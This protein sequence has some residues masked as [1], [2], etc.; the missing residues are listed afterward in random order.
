MTAP[1]RPKTEAQARRWLKEAQHREEAAK[2]RKARNAWRRVRQRRAHILRAIERRDNLAKHPHIVHHKH[3]V[4]PGFEYVVRGGT[5][6]ER[7]IFAWRYAHH[8]ARLHYSEPGL[9]LP[10]Y[11]LHNVPSDDDRSDCSW[12]FLECR[13]VCGLPDFVHGDTVRYTESIRELGREVDQHFAERH[14]GVAVLFG[15]PTFHVGMSV[16]SKDHPSDEIWQHGTPTFRKGTF[17]QFGPGTEVRFA[18]FE[19]KGA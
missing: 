2:T 9:Y 5:E 17:G 1:Y 15:S 18:T 4:S 7:Q 10:G 16:G 8:H 14:T 3:P 13:R 11:F 19:R 6:A 12:A